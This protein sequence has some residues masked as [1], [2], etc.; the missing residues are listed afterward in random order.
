MTKCPVGLLYCK[1][2]KNAAS[3]GGSSVTV[4]LC[5]R[6]SHAQTGFKLP[7]PLWDQY[8]KWEQYAVVWVVHL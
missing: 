8:G 7:S 6:L 2:Y 3:R 5:G 1:R 4:V